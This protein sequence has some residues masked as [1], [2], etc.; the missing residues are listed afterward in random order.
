MLKPTQ[1]LD[2]ALVD[3]VIERDPD[4]GRRRDGQRTPLRRVI[5]DLRGSAAT[6]RERDQQQQQ[7][8][9]GCF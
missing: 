2:G 4:R 3:G 7:G 9:G 5:D 1:A 6:G 8:G